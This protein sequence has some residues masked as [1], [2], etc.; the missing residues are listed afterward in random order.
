MS[1]QDWVEVFLLMFGIPVLTLFL[2]AFYIWD[3]T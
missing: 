1:T 2:G 3:N